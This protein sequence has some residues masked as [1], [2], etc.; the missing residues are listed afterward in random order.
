MS[1]RTSAFFRL[2]LLA[3]LCGRHAKIQPRFRLSEAAVGRE[4]SSFG[5][6]VYYYGVRT[7]TQFGVQLSSRWYRRARG[8]PYAL[9]A[10]FSV[11][12]S[13]CA[14]CWRRGAGGRQIRTFL[15]T[16]VKT[17]IDGNTQLQSQQCCCSLS[18][19]DLMSHSVAE[20][21]H[22]VLKFCTRT[23]RVCE[24]GPDG[25]PRPLA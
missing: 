15:I 4:F 3:S 16:S 21:L 12:V 25:L 10:I 13:I 17:V 24:R 22:A 14:T 18:G 1:A 8:R 6:G 11:V 9:H 7:S 5:V 23:H 2:R 20:K 19:S